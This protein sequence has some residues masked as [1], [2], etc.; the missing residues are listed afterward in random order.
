MLEILKG[1]SGFLLF[2]QQEKMHLK[3]CMQGNGQRAKENVFSGSNRSLGTAFNM[4][5]VQ[6]N[7]VLMCV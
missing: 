2:I 7:I 5:H 1:E 6:L 4:W 3:N